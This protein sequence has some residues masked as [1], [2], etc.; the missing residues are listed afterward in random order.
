MILNSFFIMCEGLKGRLLAFPGLFNKGEERTPPCVNVLPDEK[1]ADNYIGTLDRS[2]IEVA[3]IF[4][5]G[6]DLR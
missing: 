2:N 6:I 5:N 1:S 3:A 4:I